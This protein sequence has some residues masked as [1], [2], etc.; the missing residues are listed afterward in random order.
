MEK[1][2]KI[3]LILC[4]ALFELLLFMSVVNFYM[5]KNYNDC[6]VKFNKCS[7][8]CPKYNEKYHE[9]FVGI[10]NNLLNITKMIKIGEEYENVK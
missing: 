7:E 5:A 6:A 8:L 3:L 4:F 10:D 9:R 2:I 1:K